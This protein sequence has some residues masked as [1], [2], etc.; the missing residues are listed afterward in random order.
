MDF[1]HNR[2]PDFTP[3]ELR[4]SDYLSIQRRV[5]SVSDWRWKIYNEDSSQNNECTLMNKI[6]SATLILGVVCAVSTSALAADPNCQTDNVRLYPCVGKP[7]NRDRG[8]ETARLREWED[9]LALRSAT[10]QPCTG[11]TALREFCIGPLP[12]ALLALCGQPG[13]AYYNVTD[14]GNEVYRYYVEFSLQ[15]VEG[16]YSYPDISCN[17]GVRPNG[18]PDNVVFK[19]GPISEATK[20]QII[21]LRMSYL[22]CTE[23]HYNSVAPGTPFRKLLEQKYGRG[24]SVGDTRDRLRGIVPPEPSLKDG[25]VVMGDPSE[26]NAV[27]F[28]TTNDDVVVVQRGS[29][30]EGVGYCAS[31]GGGEVHWNATLL[32]QPM[33]QRS[34]SFVEA[35]AKADLERRAKAKAPPKF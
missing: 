26:A 32:N 9:R 10:T 6:S 18:T 35:S 5:S 11:R 14:D 7:G 2:P 23:P 4:R 22:I 25:K 12:P 28:V 3:I 27:V 17:F 20:D 34:L 13:T 1:L 33:I 24:R 30:P 29:G 8:M 19:L 21:V 31:R 15:R 16:F